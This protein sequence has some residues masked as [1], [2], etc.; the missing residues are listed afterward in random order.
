MLLASVSFLYAQQPAFPTAEGFGKFT[1]GGRGT[2]SIPTTVFE[3]TNLTDVNTIGS[4][5]YAINATATHRTIVFRVSGTIRL[6]SK[7][8]IKSNTTIAGQSAPGDGICL[9]DYPV[10]LN[11]NNIIVRY[12]RFRMGDKNQLL[13]SPANCGV[14]V[15]PFTAACM[16]LDGSGGDDAFGGTGYKNIIIDHCT[17]SWSTDEA[18]T[19]YRGDSTTMQWCMMSE[20]LN[21]SYHF[22]TGDTDFERHGY[23]GIWG[24]Q[25]ASF[26]HNLFAHLQG[27]VP[28]FDGSRNLGNGA[29]PGLENA[30]FRNNVLYNWASYNTNG[31]EGGNYNIVNNYYKYGPSTSTGSSSGVSIRYEVINPGKQATP[32]LPY[33][34]YYLS[35]NYVDG[36]IANTNNNWLGAAMSGGSYADTASAKVTVPFATIAVNTHV[37]LDAYNY[38]LATGGCSLPKRD[39]LDA[40]IINDVKNRTGRIIDVQ[41]GYPHG[42]PF[43]NTVNAW[44]TLASL[45]APTDT[46][47]DGMPDSWEIARGLNSNDAND[48]NIYN[49]NGYTNLENYLN[50]DSIVARGTS[51][52][53]ISSKAVNSSNSNNWLHLTDTAYSITTAIDTLNLIASIRDNSDLG[54]LRASYYT[55]NTTRTNNSRAYLNRNVTISSTATISSPVTL[56]LYLTIAEFNTLKT[57]DPLISTIADLKVFRTPANACITALGTTYDTLALTTSA[58][59][60][61]Y[62]NGYFVELN[63]NTLGTFFLGGASFATGVSNILQN[64]F[65]KVLPNPFHDELIIQSSYT[66]PLKGQ[67]IDINGRSIKEI[68]SIKSGNNTINTNCLPKGV[69]VLKVVVN[70]E[71]FTQTIIKQ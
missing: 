43:A 54:S 28:R 17:S 48:R 33:G 32:V 63:T 24:G 56:R 31:G 59:F 66:Q 2:T 18:M 6:T 23:G 50:G 47:H 62:A 16:P 30:D 38:V 26:H 29:T 5:R 15:A 67:I 12:I 10:A 36:S 8:N 45:T 13:T 42:T 52:T 19:I 40:R 49:A 64:K 20:P 71:V 27:R 21:Y 37:A 11:G 69:Y 70:K 7:L 4:L 51:N 22:E 35:G 65:L 46:D 58:V 3:V 34:K 68:T 60:G 55:T 25:K 57:A 1:T 39:T 53:C 14:P 9:A 44:P 61:T 41:G